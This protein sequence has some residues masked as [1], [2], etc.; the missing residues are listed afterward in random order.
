MTWQTVDFEE[1]ARD[2][3]FD[4][5][6]GLAPNVSPAIVWRAPDRIRVLLHQ[7]DLTLP[8]LAFDTN[9]FIDPT[10]DMIIVDGNL[11]IA[12][13]LDV[14]QWDV[15][16][17][18]YL[19]VT[20][21]LAATNIFLTQQFEL[22]VRGDLRVSGVVLGQEGSTGRLRCTGTLAAPVTVM[23][24]FPLHTGGAQGALFAQIRQGEAEPSHW[25]ITTPTTT[26]ILV[27]E[28]DNGQAWLLRLPDGLAQ[29]DIATDE[30]AATCSILTPAAL[31]DYT[32]MGGP[33]SLKQLLRQH[34]PTAFR[35]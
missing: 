31:A 25:T 26:P 8:G 2:G 33:L 12:G 34:G 1:L 23:A 7:G 6:S 27:E 18:G 30:Q 19:L 24:D 9:S 20:G 17:P 11:T 21:D 3:L 14:E 10:A 29:E 35:R 4:H 13:D 22:M 28:D 16:T 5:A 15:G 32:G